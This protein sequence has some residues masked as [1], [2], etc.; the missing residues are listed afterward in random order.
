MTKDSNKNQQC[1]KKNNPKQYKTRKKEQG[2]FIS[3]KTFFNKFKTVIQVLLPLLGLTTWFLVDFKSLKKEYLDEPSASNFPYY[4]LETIPE[5]KRLNNLYDKT[6]ESIYIDHM[7]EIIA[8]NFHNLRRKNP[9]KFNE[10][11]NQLDFLNSA[12]IVIS[13]PILPYMGLINFKILSRDDWHDIEFVARTKEE[14]TQ[15]YFKSKFNVW[16][17]TQIVLN[18]HK[19]NKYTRRSI[20]LNYAIHRL[21]KRYNSVNDPEI[22]KKFEFSGILSNYNPESG[23]LTL[24]SLLL[25]PSKSTNESVV[26]NEDVLLFEN[27]RGISGEIAETLEASFITNNDRSVK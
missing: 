14:V 25:R 5:L 16:W 22:I 26:R 17:E 11:F 21:N 24:E 7:V 6:G 23:I 10:T 9:D 1:K 18:D 3:L 27:I 4:S 2:Y 8:Y 15:N 12:N 19:G 20:V 13:N